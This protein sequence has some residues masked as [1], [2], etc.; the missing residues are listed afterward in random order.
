MPYYSLYAIRKVG[1]RC[2]VKAK[3]KSEAIEIAENEQWV[4]DKDISWEITSVNK[5]DD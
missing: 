5:E 2:I 3:N 1:E 4:I